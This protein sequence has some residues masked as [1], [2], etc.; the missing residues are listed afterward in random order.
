MGNDTG[1]TGISASSKLQV[2][3]EKTYRVQKDAMAEFGDLKGTRRGAYALND[4]TVIWFPTLTQSEDDIANRGYGGIEKDGGK[5][6]IEIAADE[7]RLDRILKGRGSPRIA[8]P[9]HKGEDYRFAGLYKF[10]RVDKPNRRVIW[11]RI[12]TEIGTNDYPVVKGEGKQ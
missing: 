8:F 4:S 7:K 5:T 3:Q 12:S 1:V 2:G 9:R 10:D 6:I 11:K